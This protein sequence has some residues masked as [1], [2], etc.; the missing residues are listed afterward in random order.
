MDG[1]VEAARGRERGGAARVL[2]LVGLEFGLMVGSAVVDRG[3][4]LTR[5]LLRAS[6][7]N[8]L[9][10]RILEKALTLELRHFEDSD[11]YDKM[12]NA[13]REA[14]SRPLALVMDAFSIVRNL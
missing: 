11:T 13:R 1:V 6:L 2:R 10:E 9:N 12:Q 14:N 7:G 8:L 4:S 3:L 5:E